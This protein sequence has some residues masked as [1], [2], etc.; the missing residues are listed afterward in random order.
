MKI[1]A[2]LLFNT[3]YNNPHR[4]NEH[5]IC[6]V[7]FEKN[8]NQGFVVTTTV[9]L[10]HK[11]R[12]GRVEFSYQRSDRDRIK[13]FGADPS[14]FSTDILKGRNFCKN[15]PLYFQTIG[16]RFR[17]GFWGRDGPIFFWIFWTDRKMFCLGPARPRLLI[18]TIRTRQFLTCNE[19]KL[20]LKKKWTDKLTISSSKKLIWSC[21]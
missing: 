1:W 5:A 4:Q 17:P 11:L 12:V 2:N 9:D 19:T 15:Y 14:H 7:N 6:W 13:K 10:Y 18:F 21:S 3:K 16:V 8:H 20:V